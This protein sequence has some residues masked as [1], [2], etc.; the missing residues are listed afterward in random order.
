VFNF[1]PHGGPAKPPGVTVRKGPWKLI[2][3]SETGRDY[4][5]E[6]ELYNLKED[7]GET[8]NLADEHSELVEEL[9]SRIDRFLADTGALVPK[10]N[11]KYDPAG[12][13]PGE[14]R[15]RKG[16]ARTRPRAGGAD[17]EEN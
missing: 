10:P 7:L 14:A 4:P 12:R 9:N 5:S 17:S 6:F 13:D 3:W 1:F 8:E 16:K 15:P 11:P 2:R